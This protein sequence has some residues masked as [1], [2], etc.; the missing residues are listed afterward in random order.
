MSTD[1]APAVVISIEPRSAWTTSWPPGWTLKDLVIL[2]WALPQPVTA[3]RAI[4]ATPVASVVNE[5]S[6]FNF[7][8]V[9]DVRERHSAASRT[10]A[11]RAPQFV[12]ITR[13]PPALFQLSFRR[14]SFRRKS[15]PVPGQNSHWLSSGGVLHRPSA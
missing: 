2:S 9:V 3:T 15:G 12:I 7:M 10:P 1:S 14:A 8:V 6:R 5:F 11:I 13:E 4:N